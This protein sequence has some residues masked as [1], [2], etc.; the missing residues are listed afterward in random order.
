MP[1]APQK[2]RLTKAGA[3]TAFGAVH[4][5][6]LLPASEVKSAEAGLKVKAAYS[7][8]RS[9]RWQPVTAAT[10]LRRGDLVKVRYEI[11]AERDFDFVSLKEGRPACME[12]LEAL[13]GYDYRS[14]CYREVGEASS[15]YFFERMAKGLHVV[16]T[17]MRADRSGRFSSSAP[18]VQCVYAP[19]F[20]GRGEAVT[21][22]VE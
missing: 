13:S 2:L 19:E 6:Y 7:V 10:V 5:S 14:D 8:K 20:S 16:E 3:T 22:R 4:A 12:P 21:L 1:S 11:R 9:G 15:H 18:L 17:E